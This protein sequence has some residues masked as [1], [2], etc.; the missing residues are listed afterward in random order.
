MVYSVPEESKKLLQTAILDNEKINVPTSIKRWIDKVKFEG[1]DNPVIPI[2]WRF[3][4]SISSL[5]GYEAMVLLELLDKKYGDDSQTITINTDHTQL[6][7]MSAVICGFKTESDYFPVGTPNYGKT[8]KDVFSVQ[9]S[10]KDTDPYSIVATNIYKTKDDKFYHIHGSMNASVIQKAIGFSTESPIESKD[11]NDV[12]P[13]Y[14]KRISELNADE[15]DDLSNN[16]YGQAGTI[17]YTSEEFKAT[18]HYKANEHVDLFETHSID[19]GTPASWWSQ[20]GS[21]ERPLSGLKVLDITRVIAA[22]TIGRTLAEF[23]AT[24]LRVTS[25]NLPDLHVLNPEMNGSKYNCSL[26]F[27]NPD[28]LAKL[29]TLIEEA[30]VVI[31]GYRPHHLDKYG[32]GKE[33]LL[34]AAKKRGRGIVYIRENCYG[35][36]GPWAGRTGWQQ[37]SDACCGVSWKFG[38]S[39]GVEEPITPVFPNSDFCTGTAGATAVIQALIEKSQKGGSY[40]ID[41]ALNYYSQWLV[42]KVGTY[43]DDMWKTLWETNGKLSP[44][45]YYTMLQLLPMYIGVL[46]KNAPNMWNPR[47][48]ELRPIVD[49][50]IQFKTVKSVHQFDGETKPGFDVPVRGNGRDP[51]AW[52]ASA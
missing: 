31:E 47:F 2:N 41:C 37:I 10:V 5:K 17:C 49:S 24:V 38:Q 32:L 9:G 20:G 51:A 14:Q 12:W 7:I 22:P 19:D 13:I 29:H 26:D 36:N 40:V 16:Q 3:A 25:P 46:K 48:F 33:N 34:K 44:R 27:K 43:S 30:D 21:V 50:S 15:L 1:T 18:E 39:V 45:H 28:D 11:F 23:G 35:W 8:L 4:E 6:F 42:D 52:P